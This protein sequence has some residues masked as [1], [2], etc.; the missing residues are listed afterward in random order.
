M[1]PDGQS[2][3]NFYDS[4]GWQKANEKT[5]NDSAIFVDGRPVLDFYKRRVFDRV[6]KELKREGKYFLDAGSGALPNL[7]RAS[8]FE[9]IICVDISIVGLVEA[10]KQLGARGSCVVADL[11]HL[12]FRDNIFDAILCSHA[13][14]HVP[15]DDQATVVAELYRTLHA[16][17]R[18]VVIYN[19][20]NSPL[21]TLAAHL[22]G[23]GLLAK[24]RQLVLLLKHRLPARRKAARGRDRSDCEDKQAIP[25]SV[26]LYY[27][28]HD[29]EWFIENA[30][31]GADIQIKPWESAGQTFTRSL[32]PSGPIGSGLLLLVLFFEKI[33]P[34]LMIRL[35]A[36][37]YVVL[38]KP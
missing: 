36:Y 1:L 3:R 6:S 34:G 8:G 20:T 22:D 10:Q 4:F 12:P 33:C 30:P 35:G 23:H 26:S 9:R 29:H 27:H 16:G 14:Y 37:F 28:G 18:C 21:E 32:V 5:F 15:K 31:P 11:A 38:Q 19:R 25:S 24:A 17:E 13:L 2:T 7:H